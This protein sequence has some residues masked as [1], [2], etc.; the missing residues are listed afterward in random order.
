VR[1]ASPGG[2]VWS[3]EKGHGDGINV[4]RMDPIP[5]GWEPTQGKMPRFFRLDLAARFLYAAKQDSDTI[6]TFRINPIC[7]A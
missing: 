7:P 6:V 3:P 4:Y 2:R 5:V 1:R